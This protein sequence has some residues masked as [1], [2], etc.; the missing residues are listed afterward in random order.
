MVVLYGTIVITKFTCQ[1]YQH[2][3]RL[4]N[5]IDQIYQHF[6]WLEKIVHTT[7]KVWLEMLT[8]QCTGKFDR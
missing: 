5:F 6:L 2:L 3:L 8:I 7:E 1:V 4:E